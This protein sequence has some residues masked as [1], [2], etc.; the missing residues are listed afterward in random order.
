M[1][2]MKCGSSKSR[3]E[4]LLVVLIADIARGPDDFAFFVLECF[5]GHEKT[6]DFLRPLNNLV[7]ASVLRE[8]I[9][10]Y[11]LIFKNFLRDV[12]YHFNFV[13]KTAGLIISCGFEL[14]SS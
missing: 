14:H 5:L 7:V 2:R 12:V 10:E 6:Q 4:C 1:F 3:V 13:L 8:D 11:K 9:V